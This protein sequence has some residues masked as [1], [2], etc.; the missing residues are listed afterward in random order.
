MLLYSYEERKKK[1]DILLYS[2]VRKER[3]VEQK[4]GRKRKSHIAL[5]RKHIPHQMT[6]N[7]LIVVHNI[8]KLYNIKNF[9]KK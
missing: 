5:T 9:G 3:L 6:V 2:Q 8:P 7:R 4:K 1:K